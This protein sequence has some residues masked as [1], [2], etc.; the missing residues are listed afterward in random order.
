M[1]K[2]L[3]NFLILIILVLGAAARIDVAKV[4]SAEVAPVQQPS[5]YSREAAEVKALSYIIDEPI[6]EEP[7]P[8]IDY[9]N[10]FVP[11]AGIKISL[12]DFN[13]L[14]RA[15]Y[16]EAG[17]QSLRAQQLVATVI[18]N[19]II[20]EDFP[21]NMHDVIYQENGKQFN[22]VRRSDLETVDFRQGKDI[23]ETACFLAIATYPETDFNMLYFR[24]DK[25]HEG[26][27]YEDYT[28]DGD[29][30]FSLGVKDEN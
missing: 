13:L 20:S 9:D 8:M 27:S 19:R 11:W 16:C 23:T 7:E 28:Y 30:Y 25:Y 26:S 12:Q 17:N 21:N 18:L 3:I 4:E 6:Y 14:C 29:M 24:S 10:Y 22:V 5:A 1:K 15:T 2:F